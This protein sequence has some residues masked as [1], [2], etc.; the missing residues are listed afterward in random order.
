MAAK[1]W[2][3]QGRSPRR[4]LWDRVRTLANQYSDPVIKLLEIPG[5]FVP[6]APV[7]LTKVN[8]LFG[9]D[10]N[11]TALDSSEVMAP[12][13]GAP[14][15]FES[16]D[17]TEPVFKEGVQLF[18]SVSHNGKGNQQIL[19]ERLDLHLIAFEPAPISSFEGALEAGA[20]H[21]AGQLDPMRFFVELDG[22]EVKR[23]RRSIRSADGKT[24]VLKAE[25]AN[26]LDTDPG[27][28]LTLAPNEGHAMF[29]ITV[30][31]MSPGLYRFCLR[32]FY[33]VAARELR[34]H[35]SLPVAIY[36]GVQ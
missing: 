31:A 11:I 9:A 4:E 5:A 1:L 22:T 21:G 28:F 23:A 14:G 19:L 35:T 32:W 27:S 2:V 26:F 30:T 25:T 13:D 12:L 36:K 6:G 29:R 20:V 18:L 3:W 17:G 10:L 15:P 24:G 34:Q 8:A 7:A 16:I 33:R